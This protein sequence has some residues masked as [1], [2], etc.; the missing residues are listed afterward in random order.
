MLLWSKLK[1][2]ASNVTYVADMRKKRLFCDIYGILIDM[3]IEQ[4]RKEE[5]NYEIDL[6]H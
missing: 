1:V 3:C 5:I 4:R 6:D 2:I